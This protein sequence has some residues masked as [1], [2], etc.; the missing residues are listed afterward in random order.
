[1]KKSL[2]L[3]INDIECEFLPISGKK[4]YKLSKKS[5]PITENYMFF[6]KLYARLKKKTDFGHPQMFA[7]L[8]TLFG[9]SSRAYD[10][11]KCSFSYLF[12]IKIKKNGKKSKYVFNFTDRKGNFTFSY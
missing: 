8:Q 6:F 7:A 10:N 11:Y 2:E 12:K 1:M 5:I 9:K 4:Y 3:K